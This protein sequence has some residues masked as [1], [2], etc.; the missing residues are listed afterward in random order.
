MALKLAKPPNPTRKPMFHPSEQNPEKRV[1]AYA[2]LSPC[3]SCFTLSAPLIDLIRRPKMI[4]TRKY[5]NESKARPAR[6]GTVV[7]VSC[8]G[9]TMKNDSSPNQKQ[10]NKKRASMPDP[11][12]CVE[13]LLGRPK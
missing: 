4:I 7:G 2:Q 5:R 8:T 10:E 1:L 11:I 9:D 13:R 3:E 12:E 6:V